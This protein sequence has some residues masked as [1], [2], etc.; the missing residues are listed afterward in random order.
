MGAASGKIRSP[1]SSGSTRLRSRYVPA[2]KKLWLAMRDGV[3]V[4]PSDNAAFPWC[5]RAA[6]AGD[7]LSNVQLGRYYRAGVGGEQ[8]DA[9]AARL[10]Y[11]AAADGDPDG[12][13]EL[14]RCFEGGHGVEQDLDEAV[15]WYA[16]AALS[17]SPDA[18]ATRRAH[19]CSCRCRRRR[20]WW[21]S[22]LH[23]PTSR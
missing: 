11:R 16:V 8:N 13:L 7:P 3:G 20:C 9:E 17:A 21:R 10:F 4:I 2:Y 19:L 23:R 5:K 18:S 22:K 15:R 1:R 12:A 6:E 14:G